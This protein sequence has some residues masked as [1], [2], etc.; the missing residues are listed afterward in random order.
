MAF[1][2]GDRVVIVRS[3]SE[4]MVGRVGTVTTGLVETIV[5][6]GPLTI[7]WPVGTMLH[8]LD[9]PSEHTP[10]KFVCYPP[11]CLQLYRDD[12]R[13]RGAW[14]PL[15]MRLCHVKENT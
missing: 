12:G 15:L 5:Q 6:P 13:E 7:W 2:I 14:T 10:G 9:I 4:H 11:E 3:P 8:G 1:K